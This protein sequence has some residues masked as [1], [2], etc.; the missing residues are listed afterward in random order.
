MSPTEFANYIKQRA[1]MQQQQIVVGSGGLQQQQQRPVSPVQQHHRG[2][3]GDAASN[4]FFQHQQYNNNHQGGG[5]AGYQRPRQSNGYH[6]NSGNMVTADYAPPQLQFAN[7]GSSGWQ[8]FGGDFGPQHFGGSP[9]GPL[10]PANYGTGQ[11]MQSAAT[12]MHQQHQQ[13]QQQQKMQD[14]YNAMGL[15]SSTSASYRSSPF[16]HLLVAN[17]FLPA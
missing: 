12:P 7:G 2:Q 8:N 6:R 10:S 1:A 3:N 5:S 13:Q 11:Q 9:M 14:N 16:Q 4:Y 17:W 15:G